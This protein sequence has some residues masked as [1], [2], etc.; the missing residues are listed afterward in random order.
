M[1]YLIPLY[2]IIFLNLCFL[3]ILF[4]KQRFG[5]FK[6]KL[7]LIIV[8][9][10]LFLIPY[11]IKLHINSF[12]IENCIKIGDDIEGIISS[13]KIFNNRLPLSIE[14]L[15]NYNDYREKLKYL[16]I[17]LK[18]PQFN[19]QVFRDSDNTPISYKFYYYGFDNDDDSLNKTY[20]LV[21][22]SALNP[23]RNG[24]ILIKEGPLLFK[25]LRIPQ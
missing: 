2:A 5:I 20:Q 18:P 19:F 6:K 17:P 12:I 25:T 22:Q 11:T 16:F 10:T 24:D 13:Y 1:Q 23:F 8:I 9:S 4:K 21:I 15:E 7:S 14:D 3:L